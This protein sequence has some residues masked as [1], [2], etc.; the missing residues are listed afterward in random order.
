MPKKSELNLYTVSIL[1]KL[2]K[3]SCTCGKIEQSENEQNQRVKEE[4]I[5]HKIVSKVTSQRAFALDITK[6]N[7]T[8][9]CAR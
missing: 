7:Y 8:K 9:L 1:R 4:I 6:M 3:T 2:D 5:F